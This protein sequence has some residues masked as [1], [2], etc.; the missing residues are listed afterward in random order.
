MK[1]KETSKQYKQDLKSYKPDNKHFASELDALKADGL[2]KDDILQEI[3]ILIVNEAGEVL[4]IFLGYTVPL[5]F[6]E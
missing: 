5:K 6:T 4:L 2:T 3:T 1:P